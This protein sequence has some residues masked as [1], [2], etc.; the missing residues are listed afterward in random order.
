MIVGN[1]IALTSA[2]SEVLRMSPTGRV[3]MVRKNAFTPIDRK[4]ARAGFTLIELLVVIAIIAILA[5]ILFPVFAKAREKARQTNCLSNLKQLGLAAMQYCNDYDETYP[6][7]I[8]ATGN[9][10]PY[11]GVTSIVG[12]LSPYTK[13]AGV[14]KCP[15]QQGTGLSQ[16][17]T[18]PGMDCPIHYACN[19]ELLGIWMVTLN[20][21][22]VINL[23]SMTR[24]SDTVMIFDWNALAADNGR[25]RYATY[26]AGFEYDWYVSAMPAMTKTHNEGMNVTFADGHAKCVKG[27]M[28]TGTAFHI[29][30]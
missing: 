26:M 19:E 1:V 30:Q 24:P 23:A 29:D 11:G 5:A 6:F 12:E 22:H 8:V 2:G 7:V 9:K 16:V 18:F 27:T 20:I 10:Q 14:W 3:I 21:V 15:S 4:A 17:S 13:S 28:I 25:T